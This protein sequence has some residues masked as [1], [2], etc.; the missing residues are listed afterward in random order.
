MK[1]CCVYLSTMHGGLVSALCGR[2][3]YSFLPSFPLLRIC[4]AAGVTGNLFDVYLKPYFLEAYRPVTK[5]DLFLV[6]QVREV[7]WGGSSLAWSP[8]S[9]FLSFSFP[10][11]LY[12]FRLIFPHHLVYTCA[13]L[14]KFVMCSS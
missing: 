7:P 8:P 13:T 9:L 3:P 4:R 11:P 1:L 5:G 2:H 10:V 14:S 6:R 12:P